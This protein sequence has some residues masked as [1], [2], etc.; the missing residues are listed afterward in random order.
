M[1]PQNSLFDRLINRTRRPRVLLGIA[2]LFII[3]L[4]FAVFLDGVYDEFTKSFSWRGLLIPSTIIVYILAVAPGMQRMEKRV[5]HTFQAILLMGDAE[6]E[7]MIHQ[8]AKIESRRELIA[9]GI[10]F[11]I[12][13]FAAIGSMGGALTWVTTYWLITTIAM[14]ALLMWTIYI[15]IAS[16]RQIS[17]LLKQPLNVDPFNTTP[18]EPIGRQSLMIALVF[19]GGITISLVFIGIDYA[20]FRQPFFWL[21]YVPL[22]MVPVILFFLNMLPTHRVLA[23]AKNTEL[24]AVREQLHK[25]C[26]A[27]LKKLET[28]Q[29][30]GNIPK[31][32]NALAVYE[33]QL[34]ETRTWPYNTATLRT[35]F[36][37][38]MIPVGTLVGRII[39]EAL[40]N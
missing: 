32:I 30:T 26:R 19:I 2:V 40:A 38:V 6:F 8:T 35:L 14:Y 39:V 25:S 31:E 12:G 5:L 11:M 36:F 10:G 13:V 27:I 28:S 17:T 20:S 29:E 15:S 22:A 34:R 16:T 24:T 37:S 9:I 21:V 7:G 3:S 1:K 33:K 4:L 23:N 18:F